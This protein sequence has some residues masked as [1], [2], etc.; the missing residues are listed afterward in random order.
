[1]CIFEIRNI[2]PTL[3]TEKGAIPAIIYRKFWAWAGQRGGADR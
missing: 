3:I 2:I 1:M